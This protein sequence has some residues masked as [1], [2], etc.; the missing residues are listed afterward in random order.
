MGQLRAALI[1]VTTF[2]FVCSQVE[3]QGQK[4]PE[5]SVCKVLNINDQIRIVL[6][7]K[8]HEVI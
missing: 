2:S 1:I 8:L 7:T 4:V 6:I 5:D 3:C